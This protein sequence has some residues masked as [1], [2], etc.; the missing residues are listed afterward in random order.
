MLFISL[1]GRTYNLSILLLMD[2]RLIS[3]FRLLWIMLLWVFSYKSFGEC[4]SDGYNLVKLLGHM[5]YLC[6]A[7][8]N[9][10]EQF[11]KYLH[12]FILSISCLWGFQFSAYLS[13]LGIV[14]HF[15]RSH[16]GICVVVSQCGFNLH[17]LMAN[18]MKLLHLF[19]FFCSLLWSSRSSLVTILKHGLSAFSSMIWWSSSYIFGTSPVLNIFF[20]LWFF[21]F[22]FLIV[23]FSG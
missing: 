5:V 19:F 10:T 13:T 16:S 2:F 18:E 21:F 14:S 6:L 22:H 8:V 3:C 23:S 15:N 7:L 17:P 9:T 12:Q 4:I 1:F 20:L 11:P